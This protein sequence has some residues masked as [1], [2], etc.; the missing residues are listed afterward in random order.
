FC[1]T[2][3]KILRKLA[4]I[5][6]LGAHASSVLECPTLARR[7]RAFP[8]T[9]SASLSRKYRLGA[10]SYTIAPPFPRPPGPYFHALGCAPG[11]WETVSGDSDF[12]AAIPRHPHRIR[13]SPHPIV[14]YRGSLLGPVA[15][16]RAPG[17]PD[18]P[19]AHRLRPLPPSHP[20]R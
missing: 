5:S 16:C 2:A 9:T 18:P 8:G 11:A 1:S 17:P 19:A 14:P 6:L 13:V 15:A 12:T 20:Q 3:P 4:R 10:I 7:M